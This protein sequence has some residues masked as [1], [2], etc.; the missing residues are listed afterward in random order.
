MVAS[1]WTWLGITSAIDVSS[2]WSLTS[3]PGNV[4]TRPQ[5]GDTGILSGA[6]VAPHFIDTQLSGGTTLDLTGAGTAQFIND[7]SFFNTTSLDPS[8]VINAT[9]TATSIVT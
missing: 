4:K 7:T 2:N 8:T 6:G 1:T 9:G 3:G 5:A